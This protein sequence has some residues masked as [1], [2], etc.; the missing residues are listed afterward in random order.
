MISKHHDHYWMARAIRLAEKGGYLTRPNPKV[1]CVI[2]ANDECI[3]EGFHAYFGGDHAEINALK[4][5]QRQAQG[6]T[7]YVTL[8]PCSHVGKTGP[9]VDA[10][11]QAGIHRVVIAMQDPNP[12]VCGKGIA[13][14]KQAGI[15]VS[16]GLMEEEANALNPG[17]IKRM[18]Q[19]LPFVRCKLAMSL[20]GK[21]AMANGESQWITSQAARR[22][23]QKL[24]AGHDAI[25]TGSGTV[26]QDNPSMLVRLDELDSLS[27]ED[28]KRFKQP[29]RIV[30]DRK[31]QCDLT[32]AFFHKNS[33]VW[34][35]GYPDRGEKKTLPADVISKDLEK[36]GV[37]LLKQLMHLCAQEAMN[38]ILIE[39]GPTLAGQCLQQGILDELIIYM[40][41]KLM[42]HEARSLIDF[43][44]H[45]MQDAV[46][47]T[48][49]ESRMIGHDCRL[50]YTL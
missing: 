11:I 27:E 36:D 24:R 37:S 31:R 20:D 5:I 25:V 16:L 38:D 19:S 6:A 40:A 44:I 50:T 10:L 15:E 28:K 30:I 45:N 42:G 43:P 17:F 3:A 34:W 32:Q 48:L 8:E 7:C 13:K 33:E 41:P 14:L 47:L 26:L 1:G 39:A 9:C 12:L 23:V 21:T 29:I 18:S 35:L 49:K 46:E 22:D 4:K 2:V